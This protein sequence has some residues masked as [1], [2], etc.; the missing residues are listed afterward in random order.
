MMCSITQ[1]KEECKKRHKDTFCRIL[2]IQINGS[3][4]ARC[5]DSNPPGRRK[6]GTSHINQEVR[7][8]KSTIERK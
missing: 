7:K 6:Q 1:G 2:W 3:S 8:L 4:A 5:Q